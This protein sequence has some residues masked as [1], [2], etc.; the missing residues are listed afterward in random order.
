MCSILKEKMR[1][2][3]EIFNELHFHLTILI[4]GS[5]KMVVGAV[6]GNEVE[7][8]MVD[9]VPFPPQVSITK[10]L[11]LL[12]HGKFKETMHVIFFFI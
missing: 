1:K 9:E 6:G 12:G 4:M 7:V 5:K 10:P 11:S 8:V 3:S 2:R